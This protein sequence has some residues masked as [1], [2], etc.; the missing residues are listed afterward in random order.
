MSYKGTVVGD[1][2]LGR[3]IRDRVPAVAAQIVKTDFGHCLFV[4]GKHVTKDLRAFFPKKKGYGLARNFKMAVASD[5]KVVVVSGAYHS[6]L[7]LAPERFV[8]ISS[9]HGNENWELPQDFI[10]GKIFLSRFG[11]YVILP[12]RVGQGSTKKETCYVR[13]ITSGKDRIKPL[14]LIR[15]FRE[16][17]FTEK[18][19]WAWAV[20]YESS[21]V[22]NPKSVPISVLKVN[23]LQDYV[24]VGYASHATLSPNGEHWALINRGGG[25]RLKVGVIIDGKKVGE[26]PKQVRSMDFRRRNRLRVTTTQREIFFFSVPPY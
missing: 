13:E 15:K 3:I 11:R 4:T 19:E 25:R 23:G 16:A 9:P 20:L 24:E 12:G 2:I 6:S 21:S 10:P 22:Q 1:Q 17:V 5:G 14:G 18:T 7:G 26:V 8:L